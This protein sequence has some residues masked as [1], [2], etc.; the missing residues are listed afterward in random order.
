MKNRFNLQAPFKP[1]GDQQQAIDKLLEGL[2]ES[3]KY[4]TLLGVTGSGKT[5]TMANVIQRYQRPTL[6]MTHNKTLASQLYNEFKEFFPDN[7]VEYFVSYYNYYQ[8]EA[9]VPRSDTYIEK[10]SSINDELDKMR[11]S[12]TRSLFERDDVIIVSS[13]SCIYG[14]GS[15]EAYSGMLLYLVVGEERERS[16]I[17]AKLIE[18]QYDRN[19]LDFHRGTF[20]VRGDTIEIFPAY[21]DIAIRVEMFGDE[22]DSICSFEPLTS[23]K[24]EELPKIAIYPGSHYVSPEDEL[25]ETIRLI[26]AELK[27]R[28]EVL[29]NQNKL[30]EYQRLQ[31]RTNY[32]IEMLEETGR[33]SGVENYSRIMTR[34]KEGEAPP[35]LIDYFPRDAL[36]FMDESHVTLPQIDGMY[37]GDFS[38]KT[39]LVNYGFRLPSAL[40]NRPLKY[41]EF[42]RMVNRVIYVS[43]TPGDREL[44][45]T[46]QQVVE[47]L[48]RPTG[49]LD[50]EIE[51]RPTA[52]QVDE[53]YGVIK[54][55]IAKKERVLITTLT[56]RMAEDLTEYYAEMGL[57]IRYLHSDIDTIE[58]SEIIRDL[59]LGEFDVLV[60]I[61]L[62]REGLDIPEV[63]L[64]AIFDADK[65]GFLRSTRSLLQTS[66]RAARNVHGKVIMFAD[67]ITQS[68]QITIDET[69]RRRKL[70]REYNKLHGIIPKTIVKKIQ[71]QLVTTEEDL[72]AEPEV[73]YE[74]IKTP[75]EKEKLLKRLTKEMNQ[76]AKN[77]DFE[78]AATLRDEIEYW[79]MLDKT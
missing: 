65:E 44:L 4:Q 12:A 35:T 33:C 55:V 3:K 66:G 19:D 21:D 45:N 77:L 9:Y 24:I 1:A 11:L 30:V 18:I 52:G 50:P 74:R 64:V 20:R 69:G 8:P 25:P 60:G 62:L 58:R 59:R 5:Y 76:A 72:A 31:Q 54:E 61:N 67:K 16:Q 57:K 78:K 7:A 56:K 38:R 17:L 53:M 28:L 51:I 14:L 49:L 63:S 37:K 34:R 13:V 70:Q 6:I 42:D 23:K 48:I 39:T 26:Q 22:I 32:D 79:K 71:G 75:R 27:D 40:D 2:E 43:A 15:P 41:E 68:M 47:Q 10:D 46:S 29:H 36:V 73:A